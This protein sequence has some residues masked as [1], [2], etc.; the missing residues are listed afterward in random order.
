MVR[1]KDPPLLQVRVSFETAR[2]SPQRLIEAYARLMPTV[3]RTCLHW[4]TRPLVLVG[5]AP[6][7]SL[8]AGEIA[9]GRRAMSSPASWAKESL[10]R[11]KTRNAAR[12]FDMSRQAYL[13]CT[14]NGYFAISR[15]PTLIR[16]LSFINANTVVPP[17]GE[18]GCSKVGDR[19]RGA[20][21]SPCRR[22]SHVCA[23]SRGCAVRPQSRPAV[24][25]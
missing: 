4:R 19:G 3:R 9:R 14:P 20:R 13:L 12:P 18:D 16:T 22:R 17:D 21:A 25:R 5:A 2:L 6:W 11:F 24:E 1:R 8:D 10:G 7:A 23:E 15:R